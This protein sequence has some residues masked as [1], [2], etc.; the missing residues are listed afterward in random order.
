MVQS[1]VSSV[2]STNGVKRIMERVKPIVETKEKTMMFQCP[3]CERSFRAELHLRL[4]LRTHKKKG[5]EKKKELVDELSVNRTG[6]V[7]TS[8]EDKIKDTETY[9]SVFSAAKQYI[10]K[11]KIDNSLKEKELLFVCWSTAVNEGMDDN[12]AA[13]IARLALKEIKD[14]SKGVEKSSGSRKKNE[15]IETESKNVKLNGNEKKEITKSKSEDEHVEQE[16]NLLQTIQME[17]ANGVNEEIESFS[18]ID[19]CNEASKKQQEDGPLQAIKAAHHLE[20]MRSKRVDEQWR[21]GNSIDWSDA[22]KVVSTNANTP[23]RV[24]LGKIGL[25]I[26]T[27]T[28]LEQGMETVADV[29]ERFKRKEEK[30]EKNY[31][32]GGVAYWLRGLSFPEHGIERF[33]R[34][35]YP[36]ESE[37]SQFAAAVALSS[38]LH[39]IQ[40]A[41][42]ASAYIAAV[43]ATA[44][45]KEVLQLYKLI[46]TQTAARAAGIA[47]ACSMLAKQCALS[48]K[49]MAIA[50][51]EGLGDPISSAATL[52]EM[53][54][55]V[56]RMA[57]QEQQEKTSRVIA[58]AARHSKLVA[59]AARK[60]SFKAC[61][62][63]AL[64]I[65]SVPPKL[66]APVTGSVVATTSFSLVYS[67]PETALPKSLQL[68]LMHESGAPDL[69]S[70]HT[71]T[72]GS[73]AEKK[74]WHD[75]ELGDLSTCVERLSDQNN[76]KLV[77]S[78]TCGGA[79]QMKG[80]LVNGAIYTITL[81]YQNENGN[82]KA[83][84]ICKSIRCG[85]HCYAVVAEQGV[86][87]REKLS[88]LTKVIRVIP[89]GS[90]IISVE[91][92]LGYQNDG[93]V[94][95]QIESGGWIDI[96]NSDGTKCLE[97]V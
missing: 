45:S 71:V 92:S 41:S 76:T 74:G 87:V 31:G 20:I 94:C 82:S 96:E 52:D 60:A 23:L 48:A 14:K 6:G 43:A 97:R 38:A 39:A 84:S 5:V 79:V 64:L 42:K 73:L 24:I 81:S 70:P 36:L 58:A 8:R 17:I 80:G 1:H 63:A 13:K 11:N 89:F 7:D 62:V 57:I 18:K 93:R 9:Q 54:Y 22:V 3:H 85:L 59:R 95:I 25:G 86:K 28:F 34:V 49:Q 75:I 46:R 88:R 51:Q 29:R 77:R 37:A 53:L 27:P 30:S 72:L 35:I 4:H 65:P 40:C 44:A 33:V 15:T 2:V 47:A 16:D 32:A 12:V 68:V 61:Q 90:L 69:N 67:L 10:K 50:V 19:L 56:D 66:E 78:Y 21:P 26:Y 55:Q 83:T 91:E